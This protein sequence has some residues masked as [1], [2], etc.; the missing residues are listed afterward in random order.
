MELR[1]YA[2]IAAATAGVAGLVLSLITLLMKSG[3][4]NRTIRSQLTDVLA[5]LNAVAA[6]SRKYRIETAKERL[7]PDQ[8]AMFGFYNDQRL[9]LVGQAR[10]LIEQIPDHVSHSELSLVAQAL[11]TVGDHELACHYWENSF[12]KSPSNYIRGIHSR[13]F[14]SYLFGQGYTEL[15][16]YRFKSSISLITAD[17][18]QRRADRAETYLRWAASERYSDFLSEAAELVG[19][20]EIELSLIKS[21]PV[22]NRCAQK[23]RD[24]E[25]DWLPQS[26]LRKPD[27]TNS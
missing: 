23:I 6:E 11:G 2:V 17:S 9:F 19:H 24:Y 14:A 21:P 12:E 22:R 7:T 16:R 20:A 1:D 25:G 18:D 15:G 4:N 13:G 5:R 3:E 26:D 8:R 27:Q 10:Y